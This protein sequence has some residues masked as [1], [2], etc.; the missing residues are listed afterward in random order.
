MEKK[1]VLFLHGLEGRP[2]GT[3]PTYLKN[4]GLHVVAVPLTR[5]DLKESIKTA[6]WAIKTMKPDIIVGSSR[7]G[8]IAAHIKGHGARKILIAPAHKAFGLKPRELNETTTIL[9]CPDD[10]LV[11]YRYSEELVEKFGCKLIACG[12]NHRMSDIEALETL[13][14]E[15]TNAPA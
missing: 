7:G 3:K 1:R 8:G 12:E 10:D 5:Y 6:N 14:A 9:H 2:D 13:L 11:P 4:Q 15:V